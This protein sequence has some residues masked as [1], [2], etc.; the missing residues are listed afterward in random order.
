MI[1]FKTFLR[2]SLSWEAETVLLI[3]TTTDKYF[4]ATCQVMIKLDPEILF[5]ILIV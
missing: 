2:M 4:Y 1:K 5:L 3:M